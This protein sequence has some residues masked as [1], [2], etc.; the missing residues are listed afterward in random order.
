M[1]RIK[2]IGCGSLLMGD[3]A[4][5]CIIARKLQKMSLPK[6]IK[7]I[8]A[9]TPGLDLLNLMEPDERVI[10]IDAVVTGKGNVGDIKIYKD[11]ELPSSHQMPLS[12]HHIA[13]PETIELGKRVQPDLMPKSIEIW[14]IEVK[15]PLIRT[16]E[17]SEEVSSAIPKVIDRL[18]RELDIP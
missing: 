16:M 12:A 2:I 7:V 9:G 15:A 17:L 3:D 1:E 14:G 10:I 13:I 4:V 11:N 6:H 5:G 8:E 18:K